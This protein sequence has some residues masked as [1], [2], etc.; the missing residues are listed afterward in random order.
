MEFSE[1]VSECLKGNPEARK[2][3]YE[4]FARQMYTICMRYARNKE[5]ADDIFNQ[6]FLN[7]YEKLHQLKNPQALAGWV[8]SIFVNTSLAY[9]R[10]NYKIQDITETIDED[11]S[12][13]PDMNQAINKM[14]LDDLTS[15]IQ[16]LPEQ[17][18]RVFN[19]YVIDGFSHKEIAV[20][21]EISI[22]TSKSNLH[23]AR[24]LL[25]NK[26]IASGLINK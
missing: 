26:I 21:L 14:A 1:L 3:L 16:Q 19:L 20:K 8:K 22:G 15:L 6:S 5:D 9:G 24:R 25:K 12:W 10:K 23:D 18:K 13:T 17:Y 11:C 4:Q 2:Q 7:V